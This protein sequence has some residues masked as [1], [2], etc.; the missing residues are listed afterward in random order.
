MS[1]SPREVGLDDNLSLHFTLMTSKLLKSHYWM[2]S[3]GACVCV[4]EHVCVRMWVLRDEEILSKR[5]H[6]VDFYGVL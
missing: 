4:C 2:S 6:S 3:L 1:C 5:V